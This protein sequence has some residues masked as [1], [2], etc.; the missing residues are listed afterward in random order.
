M[1][2]RGPRRPSE[3]SWR[4]RWRALGRTIAELLRDNL[5]DR[6]ALL[7]YYGMLAV[8]PGLLV[9]VASVR[10]IGGST[11]NSVVEGI[12]SMTFGPSQQLIAD[13]IANLETT[14]RE[15]GVVALVSFVVAFYSATGYVGAFMRAANAIYDVPEGRPVWKTLPLRILITVVTGLFLAFSAL[16]VVFTGRLAEQVGAALGIAPGQIR[17]FDIAKWPIL[18]AAFALLLALLYWAAPNAR[19]GGFRWITPGSLLATIVWAAASGGFSY[20]VS[21]FDS[22]NRTYGAL[23]G[24]IIFLVWMWLTNVAV[25]LGAEFDSELARERAIASGLSRH[26]EPYLPLRDVPKEQVIQP[27]AEI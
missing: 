21:H 10:L 24:V 1:L 18:A 22:Y 8:F 17:A 19:Q 15:A 23:G 13:G 14:R 9:M 11:A 6:A 2:A 25:L 27:P 26:A 12:R 5:P 4:A 20:Y 7:T 3:L 16:V